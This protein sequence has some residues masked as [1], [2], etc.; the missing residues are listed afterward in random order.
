MS[1]MTA[2]RVRKLRRARARPHAPRA[3]SAPPPDSHDLAG[4]EPERVVDE[5]IG[6]LRHAQIGH[7]DP[8]IAFKPSLR[9]ARRDMSYPRNVRVNV[10]TRAG[11]VSARNVTFTR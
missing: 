8:H 2:M 9:P 1:E 5:Q 4:S 6:E 3:G 11:F 7:G 10:V